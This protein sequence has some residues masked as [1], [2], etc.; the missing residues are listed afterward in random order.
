MNEKIIRSLCVL[1]LLI[2]LA[3]CGG[4]GSDGDGGGYSFIDQD[5]QGKIGGS[6]WTYV[7]GKAE[8]SSSLSLD[9]YGVAPGGSGE[10]DPV[11][12]VG[13]DEVVMTI[14]PDA[15]GLYELG[16]SQTVTI[17][18]GVTNYI[19]QSGA[20]EILSI[21]KPGQVVTGRIDAE[22]DDNNY[23]NGNFTIKFCP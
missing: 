8:E 6:P 5:M 18:D 7:S 3:T 12:Y 14:V 15:V 1:A 17:F 13:V 20:V 4:N 10:C 22:W 16:P 19:V 23:V 11:A 21:D 9:I 2:A